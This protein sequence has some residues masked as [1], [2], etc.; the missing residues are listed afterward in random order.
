[1]T[2]AHAAAERNIKSAAYK[3]RDGPPHSAE[4]RPFHI[5]ILNFLIGG[6][7]L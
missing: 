2:L 6:P 7:S 4:A 5:L 1:M 3:M